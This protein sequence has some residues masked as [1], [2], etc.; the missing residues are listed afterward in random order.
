MACLIIVYFY[1][2]TT[3]DSFS[4]V[5]FFLLDYVYFENSSSNPY[6]IRRIEELNKVSYDG[7]S[8]K[9]GKAFFICYCFR[10]ILLNIWLTGC[11]GLRVSVVAVLPSDAF[12]FYLNYT[13]KNY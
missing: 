12:P 5:A 3:E 9:K 2:Q 11:N 7:N 6:L 1:A 10:Q 4:H 13:Q 8:C